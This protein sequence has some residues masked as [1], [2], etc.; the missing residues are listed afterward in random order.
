LVYPTK[1]TRDT[2]FVEIGRLVTAY[3][4]ESAAWED[5]DC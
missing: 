2:A 4:A 1:E 3:E 5:E